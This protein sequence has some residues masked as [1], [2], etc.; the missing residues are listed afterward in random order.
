MTFP[1]DIPNK[2]TGTSLMTSSQVAKKL[3][4][5]AKSLYSWMEAGN[6]PQSIRIGQMHRWRETDIDEWLSNGGSNVESS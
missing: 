3:Q 1:S 5:S 6:F 2:G 4:V